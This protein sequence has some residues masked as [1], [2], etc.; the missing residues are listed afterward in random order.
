M[1][2][3]DWCYS[4]DYKQPCKVI[5]NVSLWNETFCRVWFPVSDTVVKVKAQSLTD[6]GASSTSSQFLTYIAAAARI[7]DALTQDVLLAPIES[8][9]IPLPHQIK[10]LSRAVSGDKIRYLLADEVGLGKTIEA[11]LIMRE[12]KLR[13]MIRRILIVAPKGLVTQW[14]SEMRLHFSEDFK[15]VLPEDI[16]SIKR[17]T[18]AD[19]PWQAVQQVICPMDSVKPLDQRKGWTK[20]QVDQFNEDRFTGLVSAGWDLIIVDEAHRLGGSTDQVARFKLGQ[21]LAESAPYILLQTEVTN[22]QDSDSA[23][24]AE[25]C[26]NAFNSGDYVIVFSLCL[27]SASDGNAYAQNILGLLYDSGAG[28]AK[29]SAEAVKWMRKAAEQGNADAQYYLGGSYYYGEG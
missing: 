18:T 27:K 20:E 29:D 3:G 13:G 7:A 15:L 12:L 16:K 22:K 5:E 19:N 24:G 8:S 10:A 14:V 21:G 28:V 9:V 1:K 25:L 4:L 11:G 17:F 26:M 6:K 2:S 23:T